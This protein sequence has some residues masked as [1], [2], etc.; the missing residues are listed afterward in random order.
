M[1]LDF[2]HALHRSYDRARRRVRPSIRSAY[3]ERRRARV[4]NRLCLGVRASR[5]RRKAY[6]LDGA[7][8]AGL[9]S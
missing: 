5:A 7:T 3:N 6:V 4:V 8:S 1:D 2:R 9:A